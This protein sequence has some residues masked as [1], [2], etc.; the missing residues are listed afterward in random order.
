VLLNAGSLAALTRQHL[1]AIN[2]YS[3]IEN[4]LFPPFREIALSYF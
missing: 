3:Q 4:S 2:F 1:K